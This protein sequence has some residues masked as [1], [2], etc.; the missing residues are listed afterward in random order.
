MVAMNK[1][2]L[3]FVLAVIIALAT[4]RVA[5]DDTTPAFGWRPRR[6]S[7]EGTVIIAGVTKNSQQ[8]RVS[9]PEKSKRLRKKDTII[10]CTPPPAEP[11]V[12]REVWRRNLFECHPD[13]AIPGC[14][15]FI[16]NSEQLRVYKYV[17]SHPFPRRRTEEWSNMF[18]SYE[19]WLYDGGAKDAGEG[20]EER[21]E[22]LFAD[23]ATAGK[24][25]LWMSHFVTA[26]AVSKG[27]MINEKWTREKFDGWIW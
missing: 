20:E 23:G 2:L 13:D 11:R 6:A 1:R 12:S 17:P 21:E 26:W 25:V 19:T 14:N 18:A 15:A 4:V 22:I 3:A 7:T 16:V 8:G 9:P 24:S 5:A 10:D 27:M